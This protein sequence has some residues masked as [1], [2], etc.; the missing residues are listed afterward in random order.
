M[1]LIVDACQGFGAEING[2]PIGAFGDLVV[3]SLGRGPAKPLFAGE[4]G[5]LVVNSRRHFERALLASQHPLRGHRQVEDRCLRKELDSGYSLGLRMHPLVAL[6]AAAQLDGLGKSGYLA[7]LRAAYARARS[8]MDRI[9]LGPVLARW[10]SNRVPSGTHLP[11][12]AQSATHLDRVLATCRSGGFPVETG[13]IR[14]LQWAA[15]IACHF[16]R[17]RGR[18]IPFH[19]THRVGSCPRS[20]K[21]SFALVDIAER[22]GMTPGSVTHHVAKCCSCCAAPRY[23]D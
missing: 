20:E 9:G 18:E 11:L 19:K 8:E 22:I 17:L 3:F 2:R 10:G 7:R 1:P 14:P 15:P 12:F 13:Q 16:D 21:L 5:V 4:G 23:V 6:L